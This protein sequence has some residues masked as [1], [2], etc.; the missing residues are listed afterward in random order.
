MIEK[1]IDQI[2]DVEDDVKESYYSFLKK[3]S[4]CLETDQQYKE[5]APIDDVMHFSDDN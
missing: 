5:N 3:L 2:D 1:Q 4:I